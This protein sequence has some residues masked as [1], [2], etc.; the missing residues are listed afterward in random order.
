M[1]LLANSFQPAELNERGYSL[2][3]DFRPGNDGWGKKAEMRMRTILELR[4]APGIVEI[5]T[6]DDEQGPAPEQRGTEADMYSSDLPP[7]K[8]VKTDDAEP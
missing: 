5:S 3:C 4:K 1:Q 8:K 6:A 2:Y 7:A